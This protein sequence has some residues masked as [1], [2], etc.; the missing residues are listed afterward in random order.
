MTKNKLCSDF[1]T[2]CF[3]IERI[4]TEEY[5]TISIPTEILP[6]STAALKYIADHCETGYAL[7]LWCKWS[8]LTLGNKFREETEKEIKKHSPAIIIRQL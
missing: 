8:D 2:I 4:D 7:L 1:I 6:E 5:P 3:N